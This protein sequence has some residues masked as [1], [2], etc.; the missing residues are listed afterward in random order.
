MPDL[1]QGLL[2][3]L[4]EMLPLELSVRQRLSQLKGAMVDGRRVEFN[5][6][7]GDIDKVCA[8]IVELEQRRQ[9]IVGQIADE[10]HLSTA[11]PTAD[12]LF[13]LPMFLSTREELFE[14][15]EALRQ[16]LA[17]I[18]RLRDELDALAEQTKNYSEVLLRALQDSMQKGAYGNPSTQSRFISV[19][20]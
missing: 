3:V 10:Q 18:V 11:E 7:L 16:A 19:R 12:E 15:T 9:S 17:D 14:L 1:A 4:K 8:A 5:S 2:D 20:T 6:E 13:S